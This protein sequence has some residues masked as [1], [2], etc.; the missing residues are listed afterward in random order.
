MLLRKRKNQEEEQSNRISTFE[1]PF[2]CYDDSEEELEEESD[3][4]EDSEE[5]SEEE[6]H[7]PQKKKKERKPTKKEHKPI[8]KGKTHMKNESSR[9]ISIKIK[10][11]VRWRQMGKCN[12]IPTHPALPQYE[13]PFWKWNNGIIDASGMEFDHI[14][15]WVITRNNESENIQGLC[16]CCHKMKT[17]MFMKQGKEF[18]T[19]EIMNGKALMEVDK[20]PP[21]KKQKQE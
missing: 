12:N 2:L 16:V 14:Q 20:N 6:S 7:A 21:R 5:D 17:K 3:Y 9:Y 4:T 15:E 13:C 10:N 11:E 18:T 19:E 8:K 1:H